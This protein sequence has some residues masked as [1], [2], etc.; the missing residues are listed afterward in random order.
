MELARAEEELRAERASVYIEAKMI[1]LPSESPHWC[2][3]LL[4]CEDGNRCVQPSK[5]SLEQFLNDMQV[6]LKLQPSNV[7]DMK[8]RDVIVH[9]IRRCWN[10]YSYG[11]SMKHVELFSEWD[12]EY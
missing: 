5:E 8:E 7:K 2:K 1:C 4:W 9:S 10:F 6:Y 11:L 12:V 3:W